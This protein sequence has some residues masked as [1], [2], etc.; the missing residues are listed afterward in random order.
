MDQG[1]EA[2]AGK[3]GFIFNIQKFSVHDGPGIRDVI[4]MKGCPLRCRWC[5]NPESQNTFAEVGYIQKRCIGVKECGFCLEKCPRNAIYVT[6]NGLVDIDRHRCNNCGDCALVCPAK[7]IT[8]FGEKVVVEDILKMVEQD[9]ASWRSN[10]GITV[11]GGEPLLQSEFVSSLFKECRKR[12]INTAI[13][14]S[15]Y[16]RWE[17]IEK[18]CRYTDL[19]F[20]DIK[21]MDADKHKECTGVSNELILENLLKIS[22]SFPQTPVIVRTPIIPGFNDT[23]ENIDATIEFLS[24]VK[25]LKDYELLGYHAFGQPKYRQLGRQYLLEGLKP[26]GKDYI[27]E[28]NERVRAMLK[29]KGVL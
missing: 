28:L 8:L 14:T 6:E 10:G 3:V 27:S 23:E 16:A 17:N 24:K 19:I 11:S 22:S 29:E 15:G 2:G 1:V 9:S 18:V 12:G 4:F 25:N 21:H 5:C 7:A 20:Y 13:E 26:P